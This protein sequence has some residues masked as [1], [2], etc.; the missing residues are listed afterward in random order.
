MF[1]FSEPKV[2]IHLKGNLEKENLYS[3]EDNFCENT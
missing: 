2:N 1:I 3:A